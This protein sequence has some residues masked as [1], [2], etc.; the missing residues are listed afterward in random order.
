MT[1][2]LERRHPSDVRLGVPFR[3]HQPITLKLMA[4]SAVD[5]PQKCT[6]SWRVEQAVVDQKNGKDHPRVTRE[7]CASRVGGAGTDAAR[8]APYSRVVATIGAVSSR[9]VAVVRAL[10]ARCMASVD[11]THDAVTAGANSTDPALH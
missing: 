8:P 7:L 6:L 10:V 3:T 2:H 9:A 4:A 1:A 11:E 5:L